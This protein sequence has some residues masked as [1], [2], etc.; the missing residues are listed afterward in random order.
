MTTPTAPIPASQILAILLVSAACT[1]ALRALPF[2]IFRNDRP[3]PG[4]LV[5][6]GD[7]LPSAI[8][9]VLIIY[10][11]KGGVSDPIG[12]GIPSLAA[13]AAVI[14]S[15]KWKHSTLLSIALGT[16]LYMFLIRAL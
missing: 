14:I 6:L 15:Y 12:V 9:A 10:C 8:M 2:L 7:L 3:M 4:W 1:Y 11:M 16:V 5:R 13:A